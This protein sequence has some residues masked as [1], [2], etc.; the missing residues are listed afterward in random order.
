MALSPRFS[1]EVLSMLSGIG[2][3][4][5]GQ[6]LGASQKGITLKG[7]R[8]TTLKPMVPRK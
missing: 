6:R 7:Q 1:P 5:R 3:R 2:R 8:I 4:V